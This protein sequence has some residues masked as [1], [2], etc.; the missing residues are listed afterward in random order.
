MHR[1]DDLL[2][3]VAIQDG[4]TVKVRVLRALMGGKAADAE[5]VLQIENNYEHAA[6]G[7][8]FH[9]PFRSKVHTSNVSGRRC[10]NVPLH[11]LDP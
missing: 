1:H 7:D 4:H 9:R 6:P 3:A 10:A 5:G 2:L 8:V 11:R